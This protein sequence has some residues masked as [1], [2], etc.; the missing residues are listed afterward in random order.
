MALDRAG[1]DYQVVDISKDPEARDYVMSLGYLSAPVVV[2]DGEH[3]S[4]F[5]PDRIKEVAAA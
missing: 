1:I 3:W 4:G 5:R 2:A